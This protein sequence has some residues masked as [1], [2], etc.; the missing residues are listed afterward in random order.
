MKKPT[1]TYKKIRRNLGKAI[2]DFSLISD[3]DK[4]VV[5]IS[6]GKDSFTLLNLLVDMLAVVP[7]N[8]KLFPVYIDPGFENSFAS[9]LKNCCKKIGLNL[10]VVSSDIGIYAHSDKNTENP[11]FLCS[12]LRRKRL[13]EIADELGC[14]KI[15]LGHNKDDIIE[16]LFLN[17][18]YSGRIYTMKPSQDFFN[19]TINIIRPLSYVDEDLIIK[20]STQSDFPIFKNPCPSAGKTKRSDV[21]VFLNELY[22]TNPNIK[23]SIFK[24]LSS[25]KLDYLL[26]K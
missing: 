23:G 3:G 9:E 6:G 1:K 10:K 11:C 21:K 4:I 26:I 22:K 15:A 13:F 17:M 24:S 25:V 20:Y 14:Y 19:G 18:F 2:N 16:T 12:R 8:Y 5:G 7:I